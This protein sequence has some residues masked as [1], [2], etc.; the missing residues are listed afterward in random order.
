MAL[1][2]SVNVIKTFCLS[3]QNKQARSLY[4][5]RQKNLPGTNTPAYFGLLLAQP[6]LKDE[7]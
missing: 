3:S 6:M 4:L 7:N 2:P 1:T 5:T